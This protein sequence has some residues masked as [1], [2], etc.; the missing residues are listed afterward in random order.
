MADR[1]IE[2]YI[3]DNFDFKKAHHV[4]FTLMWCWSNGVPTERELYQR[5]RTLLRDVLQALNT[6]DEYFTETGGLRV[7]GRRID[8]RKY[9]SLMFIVTSWD[10]YE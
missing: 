5:A 2:D 7:Q 9:V 10:N 4:M 1:D 6:E 3:L 8:G